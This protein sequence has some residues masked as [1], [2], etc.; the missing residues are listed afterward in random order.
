MSAV[1]AGLTSGANENKVF[2]DAQ[3]QAGT[4]SHTLPL[5]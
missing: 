4:K 3:R 1:A 5:S 2:E